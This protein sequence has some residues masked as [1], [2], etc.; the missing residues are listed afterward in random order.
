MGMSGGLFTVP[1]PA[2]VGDT[3]VGQKNGPPLQ[4][5]QQAQSEARSAMALL[6]EHLQGHPGDA[7]AHFE[8][9]ALLSETGDVPGAIK[10]LETSVRLHP[11]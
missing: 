4:G 11:S 2:L 10:K 3:P 6:Q 7:V 8:L 1:L 5:I 9:G